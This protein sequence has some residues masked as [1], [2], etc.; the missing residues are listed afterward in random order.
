M[1]TIDS[2]IRKWILFFFMGV[3]FFVFIL[4]L[5]IFFISRSQDR[6]ENRINLGYSLF[7]FTYFLLILFMKIL[8]LDVYPINIIVIYLLICSSAYLGFVFF[9]MERYR[10]IIL[11]LS[12]LTSILLGGGLIWRGFI[13]PFYLMAALFASVYIILMLISVFKNGKR[14]WVYTISS[15][16]FIIIYLG[17]ISQ[18]MARGS[19]T[20]LPIIISSTYT[21]FIVLSFSLYLS[22]KIY[23]KNKILTLNNLRY[24]QLNC[25]LSRTVELLKSANKTIEEQKRRQGERLKR[26]VLQLD[27]LNVER[28]DFKPRVKEAVIYTLQGLTDEVI[29]SKMDRSESMVKKYLAIARDVV[30][31]EGYNLKT[32]QEL[33]AHFRSMTDF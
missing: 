9:K 32:K 28:Y 19:G 21:A 12:G 33:I 8:F 3:H 22:Y 11:F 4:H 30:N 26:Q 25:E 31:D 20:S 10:N 5:F 17:F 15:L 27:R 6:R 13:R 7:N 29:G 23:E 24:E 2:E 16:G 18:G 14:D 1:I